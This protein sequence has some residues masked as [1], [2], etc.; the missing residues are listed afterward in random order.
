MNR[1]SELVLQGLSKSEFYPDNVS[2]IPG[3]ALKNL[4]FFSHDFTGVRDR[5]ISIVKVTAHSQ[6]L[7]TQVEKPTSPELKYPPELLVLSGQY[8]SS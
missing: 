3:R 7:Q 1:I 5:H 8:F 2:N 4:F 6:I